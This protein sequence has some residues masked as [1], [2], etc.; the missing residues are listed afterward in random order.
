MLKKLVF[1]LGV[2]LTFFLQSCSDYKKTESGLEYK[3]L[4]DSAGPTAEVGDVVVFNMDFK[5]AKDTVKGVRRWPLYAKNPGSFEEGLTLLSAGDSASF[6][7]S[8]DTIY[9]EYKDSLPKGIT[10]GSFTTINVKV[11]KIMKKA[12]IQKQEAEQR[13]KMEE[14]QTKAF[15]QLAK[16]TVAIEEYLKSKKIKAK[17]T[18]YGVYY[19]I[20]KQGNGPKVNRGDMISVH[21]AGRLLSNGSEFDSSKGK[22]PFETQ[23]GVGKV[24]PGWDEVFVNVLKEGDKATI[25]V[26]SMLAYGPSGAGEKIPPYSNLIFDIEVLKVKKFDPS[27]AK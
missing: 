18:E 11:M 16:D 8:N 17:R 15:E 23:V 14:E 1:I 9:K 25:Y 19:V 26:P 22:A 13:K 21:Y 27:Q 5:N 20:T 7:I 12:D 3:I 2:S 4:N 10:K 6:K 24:I